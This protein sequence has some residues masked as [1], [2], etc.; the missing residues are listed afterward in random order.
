MAHEAVTEFWYCRECGEEVD[1]EI[2][3][4]PECEGRMTEALRGTEVVQITAL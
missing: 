2:E 3:V 1:I 4:C